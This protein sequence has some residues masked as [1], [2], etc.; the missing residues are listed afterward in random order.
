MIFSFVRRPL[1]YDRVLPRLVAVDFHLA[2][3]VGVEHVGALEAADLAERQRHLGEERMLV[4]GV[5]PEGLQRGDRVRVD[6]LQD[7]ESSWLELLQ[8]QAVEAQ[9]LLVGH[10][11]YHLG[12]EDCAYR[13]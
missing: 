5:Y 9:E 13:I 3:P 7:K 12:A 6:G 8:S 4:G 10:V 11:L 1:C 2:L